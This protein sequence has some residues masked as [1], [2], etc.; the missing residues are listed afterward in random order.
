M[1]SAVI[2]RLV[3][4]LDARFSQQGPKTPVINIQKNKLKIWKKF[5]PGAFKKI[6]LS[7]IFTIFLFVHF[8]NV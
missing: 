5:V 8:R 2:L 3:C 1:G 7:K 4:G 6:I